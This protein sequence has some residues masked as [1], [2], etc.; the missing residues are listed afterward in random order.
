MATVKV[1]RLDDK[2]V[3]KLKQRAADNNRS[4][5]AELRH[6][7]SDAVTDDDY[8]VKR[9]AFIERSEELRALTAGTR[10]TPSE[11]LIRE[12]RDNGYER[13]A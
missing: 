7:L 4:F 8:E 2:V 10:Q 6:I 5:E 1:P 9:L 12:S 3:H 11:D 13:D